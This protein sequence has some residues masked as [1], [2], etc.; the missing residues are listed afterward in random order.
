MRAEPDIHQV[1]PARFLIADQVNY[2]GPK[3]K[4][5]RLPLIQV[6]IWCHL[7]EKC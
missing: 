2:L 5:L 3:A 6:H 7:L 4:W 1:I